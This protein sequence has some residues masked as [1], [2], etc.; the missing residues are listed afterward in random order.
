MPSKPQ[1]KR[2]GLIGCGAIGSALA[3]KAKERS[4]GRAYVAYLNDKDSAKAE[5]LAKVLS[6]RPEILESEKLIATSDIVIEAASASISA[7]IARAALKAGKHVLIMSVG[8]LIDAADLFQTEKNSGAGRLYIPSGAIGGL[9]AFRAVRHERIDE[10]VLKTSK[11][12]KALA[13]AAYLKEK[14]IDLGR[15]QSPQLIF[16]GS[17][18][19]AVKYFPQN[20]NVAA[21]AALALGNIDRLRVEIYCDPALNRNVHEVSATGSFGRISFT[22]ENVP[23]EDNPKTSRLAILSALSTLEQ[24]LDAVH[25]G[26]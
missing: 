7:D 14:G 17:V 8:G 1:N 9:D 11:P 24:M 4:N 18:S 21:A 20:I 12:P 26:S 5:A 2:I 16:S 3:R 15:I 19:E 23:S 22:A 10:A 6:P 25:I 13:G